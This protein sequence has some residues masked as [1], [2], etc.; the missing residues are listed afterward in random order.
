[1]DC[2]ARGELPMNTIR[3]PECDGSLPGT[4]RY[5]PACGISRTLLG[6]RSDDKW[7]EIRQSATWRKEIAPTPNRANPAPLPP[8]PARSRPPMWNTW[9][10]LRYQIRP[11]LVV[12]ISF[13]LFLLLI[14]GGVFG[15]VVTR[16][17]GVNTQPTGPALQVTPNN[18]A[19]G[20]TVI[21]NG[22]HFKPYGKIGLT[23]DISIPVLDTANTAFIDADRNGSFADTIVITPDWDTGLHTLNAEDAFRHKVASFSIMVTAYTTILRPAHLRVSVGALNLGSGDQATNTTRTMTLTNI[24]AGFISWQGTVTQPW[25]MLSPA[26]GTFASGHSV[27]II[28]AI[29]RSKLDPGQY[30]TQIN[31]LSTV[32]NSTV[33][34]DAAV[35]PLI[36]GFN[37][38]LRTDPALLSFSAIDGGSS[39]SAQTITV[40]NPGLRSLQ[41]QA[42]TDTN[43]LF[44]SPQSGTVDPASNLPVTVHV[45]SS[46]LLPGTY[47]G[48]VTLSTGGSDANGNNLQTVSVTVTIIPQC[49]LLIAPGQLNFTSVYQEG[50]PAL[51]AINIAASSGCNMPASWNAVSNASWLT[52]D[53]TSGKTPASPNVG[54]NI[55]GLSPGVYNSSIVFSSAS[56]TQTLPVTFTLSR[57]QVSLV[58]TAPSALSFRGV[59]GQSGPAIQKISIAN[60]E[61]TGALNWTATTTGGAW[62]TVY[63]STGILM[64]HQSSSF[65]IVASVLPTLVP[66]TY[67]GTVTIS[68]TDG[69]GQPASGSPQII[70]V[71]LLVQPACTFTTSSGALKFTGTSRQ[72]AAVNQQV[73]LRINPSCTNK[74]NFTATTSGGDWLSA[75]IG[76]YYNSCRQCEYYSRTSDS[77]HLFR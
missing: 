37:A 57:T 50:T 3:C 41:W 9:R 16:G 34:V 43:W 1:M 32:G 31:I 17:S 69:Y 46:L 7:L 54:I 45:N 26:S 35:T 23:R 63:P 25:L 66:G 58:T 74:L 33:P 11:T 42:T 6:H 28:V 21:L 73:A 65:N 10:R 27:Q 67:N 71:S 61:N 15:I 59:V 22:K 53:T 14:F 49:S 12:W 4:A 44:V 72:A 76:R 13:V 75:S 55:S 60:N 36:S 18:V 40:S 29:D 64:A 56:G 39:P 20:A 70:P 8:R 2:Q 47:N 51:K 52:V 30:K 19:V 48:V 77:R 68:G 24:G 38:V 62:L 5:C